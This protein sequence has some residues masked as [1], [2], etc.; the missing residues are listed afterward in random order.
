MIKKNQSKSKKDRLIY[1]A[2]DCG[3]RP[4]RG[5]RDRKKNV[6]VLRYAVIVFSRQASQALYSVRGKKT[7]FTISSSVASLIYSLAGKTQER[8]R[9][10]AA[11]QYEGNCASPSLKQGFH[12][13]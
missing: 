5:Q 9:N 4:F 2:P 3:K 12:A 7:V 11:T 10:R 6:G 8:D 13:K 1:Y